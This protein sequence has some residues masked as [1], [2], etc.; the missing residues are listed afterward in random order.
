[1]RTAYQF[2]NEGSSCLTDREFQGFARITRVPCTGHIAGHPPAADCILRAGGAIGGAI[3]LAGKWIPGRT[4]GCIRRVE[5]PVRS[6]RPA[7]L[8]RGMKVSGAMKNKRRKLIPLSLVAA[9][10][11]L[12]HAAFA[13][14][15]ASHDK[16]NEGSSQHSTMTSDAPHH[17]ELSRTTAKD[18]KLI[19]AN[20]LF[21]ADVVGSD[22]K[23]LGDIV[24]LALDL[25]NH[26]ITHAVIM[27]GGFLDM[28]GDMRA[29][30][31]SALNLENGQYRL[32]VSENDFEKIETLPDENRIEALGSDYGDAL[33]THFPSMETNDSWSDRQDKATSSG[34][35]ALFT[36]L[37]GRNVRFAD[38]AND[39]FADVTG[40]LV[41]IGEKTVAYL[42]VDGLGSGFRPTVTSLPH[43]VMIPVSEVKEVGD[44]YVTLGITAENARD[45]DNVE[46]VEQIE[47][48][49]NER[50]VIYTI[51]MN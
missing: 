50:G 6:L 44:T 10:V 46:N 49:T 32:D 14:C 25:E 1:M 34:S 41:D 31:A 12:P 15:G 48:I 5:P 40:A 38:G 39:G 23:K 43:R 8:A 27:T 24:D 18:L 13:D 36:D 29:V 11:T 21:G 26:T 9:S 28:G 45:V 3:S 17:G 2:S 33:A 35:H 19:D 16:S 7:R 20:D 47:E 22:G 37:D 42:E 4:G 30:P 51:S